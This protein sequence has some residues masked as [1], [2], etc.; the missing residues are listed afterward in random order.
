LTLGLRSILVE[1]I[2]EHG[3]AAIDVGQGY[4]L[5]DVAEAT[6]DTATRKRM[7]GVIHA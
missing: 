2:P 7:E 5:S 3:G 6:H 4:S 1:L